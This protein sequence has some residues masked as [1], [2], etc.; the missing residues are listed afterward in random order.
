MKEMI[1][2]I[3]LAEQ[4]AKEEIDN[5]KKQ[6]AEI[7]S[8]SDAQIAEIKE[9]MKRNRRQTI[10]QAAEQARTEA[11]SQHTEPVP[12]DL[13]SLLKAYGLTEQQFE[14]V[15]QAVVEMITTSEIQ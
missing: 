6:A 5:A 7:Q 12:D 4:K 13:D 15:T 8:E 11:A 3:L 14:E 10:A 9:Q 1:E 2:S